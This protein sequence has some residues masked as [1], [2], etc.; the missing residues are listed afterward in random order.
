MLRLKWS[1]SARADLRGIVRYIRDRNPAAAARI[2]LAVEHTA[3]LLP[4]HPFLYRRGRV[5]GTR[6]AVVHPNYILVYRVTDD[7]VEIVAILHA[8]RQYPPA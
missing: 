4:N 2:A 6:E 7:F 5:P 8:R 1:T 3:E